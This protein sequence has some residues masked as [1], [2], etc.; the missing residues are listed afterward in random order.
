MTD[1]IQENKDIRARIQATWKEMI[2]LTARLANAWN[3]LGVR[4]PKDP[5]PHTPTSPQDILRGQVQ[6]PK[7]PMPKAPYEPP[8]QEGGRDEEEMKPPEFEEGESVSESKGK[9]G[10]KGE[11]PEKP[12]KDA[13]EEPEEPK[14]EKPQEPKEPKG[15]E[16]AGEK[17]ETGQEEGPDEE[18]PGDQGQGEPG[19]EKPGKERGEEKPGGESEGPG[20][21]EGGPGG[22]GEQEGPDESDID[23]DDVNERMDDFEEAADEA[24]AEVETNAGEGE[25]TIGGYADPFGGRT[26]EDPSELEDISEM[27]QQ[28]LINGNVEITTIDTVPQLGIWLPPPLYWDAWR[29]RMS[30]QMS[31]LRGQ[32]AA[33]EVH[34]TLGGTL[35]LPRAFTFERGNLRIWKKQVPDMRLEAGLHVIISCDLTAS[36]A[37]PDVVTFGGWSDSMAR[38]L[39]PPGCPFWTMT[40]ADIG[41]ERE[42]KAAAAIQSFLESDG[43]FVIDPSRN[44][45]VEFAGNEFARFHLPF[46]YPSWNGPRTNTT[47]VHAA[48]ALAYVIGQALEDV[49]S[50]TEL[51]FWSLITEP[52]AKGES[53]IPVAGWLGNVKTKE[54]RFGGRMYY[55]LSMSR[56]NSTGTGAAAK[57]ALASFKRSE[58]PGKLFLTITDARFH[59]N[60]HEYSS[61]VRAMNDAGITTALILIGGDDDASFAKQLLK[62]D[63][64][65]EHAVQ[66]AK[67]SITVG[68]TTRTEGQGRKGKI[69]SGEWLKDFMLGHQILLVSE[70]VDSLL[71]EFPSYI[72]EIQ[73]RLVDNA[74]ASIE[75]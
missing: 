30:Q 14:G 31:E 17:P 35:D 50:T 55:P 26:G 28:S 40:K 29:Q 47:R 8:Q 4:A 3:K 41:G 75:R 39:L 18:E 61:A 69:T 7:L 72:Q 70:T 68:E 21:G 6:P 27:L 37:D 63:P 65:K 60:A 43:S 42:K 59:F 25:G 12:E 58:I 67:K 5:P 45:A 36:M 38:D 10:E 71:S 44:H 52:G 64:A 15:E 23:Y 53:D 73:R 62:D 20:P 48:S 57:A 16:P 1:V 9:S 54:G 34:G 13:G 51:Y 56:G 19:G 49:D 11:K 74:R 2:P 24:E 32:L 46:N 33:Q 22:P 66:Y